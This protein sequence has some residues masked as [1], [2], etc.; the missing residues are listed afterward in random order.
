MK[1]FILKLFCFMLIVSTTLFIGTACKNED[2]SNEDNSTHV[3]EY[4]KTVI[5][6]TCDTQGYTLNECSCGKNY[7]ESFVYALGHVSTPAVKENEVLATC[8]TGGSYD[9]VV[10]CNTCGKEYSRIKIKFTCCATNPT[11]SRIIYCS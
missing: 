4:T 9:S 3:C 8:I 1:S 10:Y 5:P 7:K 11:S 6:P 2:G